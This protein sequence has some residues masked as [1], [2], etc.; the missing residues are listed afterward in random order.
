MAAFLTFYLGQSCNCIESKN[1]PLETH[2]IRIGTCL[3]AAPNTIPENVIATATGNSTIQVEWSLTDSSSIVGFHGFS[4]Q[5]KAD[6]LSNSEGEI[7]TGSIKKITLT[8][9]SIFTEYKIRVAARTTQNGNY[10]KTVSAKTWEGGK[11]KKSYMKH[12]MP[13]LRFPCASV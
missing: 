12:T 5:Y 7:L 13:F 9:L 10:S 3:F 11:N 8:K 6:G 4:V 1:A 2:R